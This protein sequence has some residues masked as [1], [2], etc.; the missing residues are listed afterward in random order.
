M[1]TLCDECGALSLDDDICDEC[2]GMMP[3]DADV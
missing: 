3:L 2:G 1:S